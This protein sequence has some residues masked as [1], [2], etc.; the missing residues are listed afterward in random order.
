[1]SETEPLCEAQIGNYVKVEE[2]IFAG[3]K[4][5]EIEGVSYC[6]TPTMTFK[7]EN[8]TDTGYQRIE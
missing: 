6:D 1:M 3:G 4:F 8:A 5:Y 7:L 2:L